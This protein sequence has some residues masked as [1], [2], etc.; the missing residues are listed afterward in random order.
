[1]QW[2]EGRECGRTNMHLSTPAD[3]P[4]LLPQYGTYFELQR[5]FPGR[6]AGIPLQCTGRWVFKTL[7]RNWYPAVLNRK[8][9]NHKAIRNLIYWQSLIPSPKWHYPCCSS[10]QISLRLLGFTWLRQHYCHGIIKPFLATPPMFPTCFSNQTSMS[11]C[12]HMPLKS[13]ELASQDDDF[14]VSNSPLHMPFLCVIWT[15]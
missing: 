5:F 9:K 7:F 13:L 10:Y 1:M 3:S 8:K 6:K 4:P 15:L 2:E 11:Q 12:Q 14:N